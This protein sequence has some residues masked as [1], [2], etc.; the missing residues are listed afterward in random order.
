M[1]KISFNKILFL[2]LSILAFTAQAHEYRYLGNHYAI[3]IGNDGEPGPTAGNHQVEVFALY[4]PDP[5]DPNTAEFLSRQAGDKVNIAVLPTKFASESYTAPI[6]QVLFPIL[7]AFQET[8][9]EDSP[10]YLSNVYNIP[11]A[12]AWGFVVTGEIQ[13]KGKSKKAFLQKFVCGA[14]THDTQFGSDFEC[15]Q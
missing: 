14:G 15:I 10:A 9:I 5:N 3:Q 1:I 4:V 13:K 7:T 8:I 11:S 2:T 12:G 6:V